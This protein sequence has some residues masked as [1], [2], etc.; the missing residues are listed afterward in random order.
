M[1]VKGA[2]DPL[3]DFYARWDAITASDVAS[4]QAAIDGATTEQDLQEFLTAQPVLLIQHL[5][6]GHGRWVL[7]KPRLGSHYVPDFIIGDRDSD[8]R[9]WIAVEL[10]SPMRPMF[11]KAGDPSRYLTRAIRQLLDWRTWLAQNRSYAIAPRDE[12]GLGLEDIDSDIAGLII[13][14]RRGLGPNPRGLRRR[15][16][17]DHRL[18]IHSFD[19]LVERADGRVASLGQGP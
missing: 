13:I 3:R 14:G 16:E 19:W 6:G 10:E 12:D 11:T 1:E 2:K 9:R 5:G 18:E 7:P 17:R 15:L 8:G 4:L